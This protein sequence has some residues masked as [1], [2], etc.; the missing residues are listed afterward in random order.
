[1]KITYLLLLIGSIMAS[2]DNYFYDINYNK[3]YELN[4][5]KFYPYTYMPA[6]SNSFFR[7]GV[8]E[9]DKMQIQLTVEKNAIISFKVDV[10]GFVS[11]PSD[12][13]VLVGHD[14]CKNNLR[15]KLDHSENDKDV[16]LY[17]FEPTKGINY[18]AI[19]IENHDALYYFSIK[20]T[21]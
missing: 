8:E 6:G 20:I 14:H 5:D 7:V 16:Y 11:R 21:S 9:D 19:H 13:Q 18:V 2:S 10:C 15:G 4:M 1:M 3:E 17:D 12:I